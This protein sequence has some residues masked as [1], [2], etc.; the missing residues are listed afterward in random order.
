MV[1]EMNW[2]KQAAVVMRESGKTS[3]TIAGRMRSQRTMLV[4]REKNVH[5]CTS[6]LKESIPLCEP[7][8]V[9]R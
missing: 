4:S 6:S 8:Q 2:T 3:E 9:Q 5:C 7:L 1:G